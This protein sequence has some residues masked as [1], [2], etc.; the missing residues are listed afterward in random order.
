MGKCSMEVF[1]VN[2]TNKNSSPIS[3]TIFFETD[4]IYW[5]G[6]F[7]L[8]I[9]FEKAKFRKEVEELTLE[10]RDLFSTESRENYSFGLI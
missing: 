4:R 8:E 7:L 6:A 10:Q 9:Y 2:T 3:Y 5:S 1:I